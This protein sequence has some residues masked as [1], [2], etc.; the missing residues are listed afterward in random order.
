MRTIFS[1]IL[2]FGSIFSFSAQADSFY[3][4]QNGK[5]YYCEQVEGG[6]QSCWEKC[7]YTFGSCVDSCGGG[8][9]C[10]DRCPYTFGSCAESCGGGS[11]CWEKCPYT[12]GSCAET[13]G[14]QEPLAP[15]VL[16]RILGTAV[17]REE[18]EKNRDQTK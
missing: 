4:E 12:F 6:T 3:L 10:W 2:V 8:S 16:K 7:P 5:K 17:E 13:C 1:L 9:E 18:A 15:N 11:S 14:N